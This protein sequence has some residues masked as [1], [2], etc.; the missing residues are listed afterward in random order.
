MHRNRG[1]LS[2]EGESLED[3]GDQDGDLEHGD[4]HADA[5]ARPGAKGHP[6]VSMTTGKL[7][8]RYIEAPRVKD[9]RVGPHRR[10]V[11]DPPHRYLDPRSSRDVVPSNDLVVAGAAVHPIGTRKKAHAFMQKAVCPLQLPDLVGTR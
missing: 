10:G 11:V 1:Q 4:L 9:L 5:S 2:L 8:W 3:S 6:R 7:S